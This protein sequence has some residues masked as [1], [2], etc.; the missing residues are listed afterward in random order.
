MSNISPENRLKELKIELPKK[1]PTAGSYVS[2]VRTGDLLFLSGSL[3]YD[4]IGKLGD[5]ITVEEGYEASR[6]AIINALSVIKA[7][8]GDLSKVKKIVKLF[9]MINTTLEFTEQAKV[10]NGASDL[11]VDIFGEDIGAHAR[12]SVGMILPRG[13]AVEID[14]VIELDD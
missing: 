9:G 2:S 4:V 10:M 6:E 5:T 13:A 8:I 3:S 14:L 12:T 1:R 11:L 7:D